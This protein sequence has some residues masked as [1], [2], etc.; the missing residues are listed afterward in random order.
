VPTPY[1]GNELA[2]QAPSPPP[3]PGVRPTANLP[4]DGDP[5]NASTYI[6]GYK[7]AMDFLAWLMNPGAQASVWLEAIHRW[8]AANG[9]TRFA[10][11]HLGFPAGQIVGWDQ[12]WA[13]S[14]LKTA[15]TG[16]PDD[17]EQAPG[18]YYGAPILAGA[19][20]SS[21]TSVSV[22]VLSYNHM[23]LRVADTLGDYTY[24]ELPR[25]LAKWSNDQHLVLEW[26]MGHVGTTITQ[27]HAGMHGAGAPGLGNMEDL[28][29]FRKDP[30]GNWFAVTRADGAYTTTD[31]GISANDAR[32]RIEWHGSTVA[33]DAT[34]AVRFYV[35]G[36]LKATHTTNLPRTSGLA[37]PFF[38]IVNTVGGSQSNKLQIG[39]AK[40]RVSLYASDIVL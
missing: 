3:T 4:A 13:M 19:G 12:P 17:I 40:H 10:I 8:R 16:L 5:P 39:P 26:L 6:Q 36:V 21:L 33:D 28:A 23:E 9:Q 37:H 38:A 34:A 1:Q 18:W 7:V 30:G 27:Y 11:D 24:L 25:A 31:T 2:T 32:F 29:E 35:N 22:G 14:V 20:V 15:I